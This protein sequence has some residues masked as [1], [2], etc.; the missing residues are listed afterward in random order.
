[1]ILFFFFLRFMNTHTSFNH[2]ASDFLL[3]WLSVHPKSTAETSQGRMD[4]F[5]GEGVILSLMALR[6]GLMGAV[7]F[8]PEAERRG[9]FGSTPL[10]RVGE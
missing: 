8:P 9:G 7:G 6:G 5:Y 10:W 3:T 2:S 4:V 1:M